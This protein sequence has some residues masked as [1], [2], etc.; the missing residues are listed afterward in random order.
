M[1]EKGRRDKEVEKERREQQKILRDIR[2][3]KR[4][5]TM[6]NRRNT[7][8]DGVTRAEDSS[9]TGNLP[10]PVTL[11]SATSAS[12][13]SGGE[14]ITSNCRAET[15]LSAAGTGLRLP[16]GQNQ[17]L[18]SVSF[19]GLALR[20]NDMFSSQSLHGFGSQTFEPPQNLHHFLYNSFNHNHTLTHLFYSA[21]R[22]VRKL[23]NQTQFK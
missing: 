14:T 15:T 9:N 22:P 3:E 18:Q 13:E 16:L 4:D 5:R 2:K 11:A 6:S 21:E 20:G 23:M 10:R 12:S 7:P 1:P 8:V 19:P 17:T